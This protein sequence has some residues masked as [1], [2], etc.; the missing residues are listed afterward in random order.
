MDQNISQLEDW[1]LIVVLS[2]V[3]A[4]I[5]NSS[6]D[7]FIFRY[8]EKQLFSSENMYNQ[9]LKQISIYRRCVQ[10][11]AFI[12]PALLDAQQRHSRGPARPCSAQ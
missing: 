2:D 12:L 5:S 11:F 6:N 10:S 3:S 4:N 1:H 7:I 8:T 9:S